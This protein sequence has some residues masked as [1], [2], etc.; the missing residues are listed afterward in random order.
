MDN[1]Q[2]SVGVNAYHYKR[3]NISKWPFRNNCN[4]VVNLD[5]SGNSDNSD[6]ST[7]R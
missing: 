7:K 6:N 4:I 2:S 1:N 3:Y 5:N